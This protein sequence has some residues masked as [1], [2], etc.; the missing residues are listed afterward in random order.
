MKS[1]SGFRGDRKDLFIAEDMSRREF[2][3][4]GVGF[5]AVVSGLQMIAGCATTETPKEQ[6]IASPAT[7]KAEPVVYPPLPYNK[8]QPPKEGCLVGLYK[9]AALTE[10]PIFGKK[11][12]EVVKKSKSM[13]EFAEMFK[14]EGLHK[15]LEQSVSDNIT[16]YEKALG[17]KP[18]IFVLTEGL[19]SGFPTTQSIEVVKR[20]IVVYVH[21]CLG[22]YFSLSPSFGLKEIVQ[23]KY[24][25]H[26]KEFA[27]GAAEF[28]KEHGSF[29]FTTMEE[30]NGNWYDWGIPTSLDHGGT[31]G[32]YL[33]TKEQ[34]NMPLGS[35]K[36]ILI[37]SYHRVW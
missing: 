27:Q 16:Y 29:F 31:F 34:T 36:R 5:A 4:A 12:K 15:G 10:S 25:N 3:K 22:S 32:K 30:G 7:V 9:R 1:L 28:G 24:D 37:G 20:G 14:K 21:A 6:V 13:D 18:F 33:K 8:V 26:I 23:G 11:L 35:G 2:L 17:A 19:Y